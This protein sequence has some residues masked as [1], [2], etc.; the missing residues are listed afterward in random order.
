LKVVVRLSQV[1]DRGGKP[2]DSAELVPVATR[3][4]AEGRQ[5][6]VSRRFKDLTSGGMDFG[7]VSGQGCGLSP[8]LPGCKSLG[9]EA[10][11]N[12]L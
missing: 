10:V 1:V 2:Y 5:L 8:R 11:A 12:H 7:E 3:V 9:E 4:Q 6:L